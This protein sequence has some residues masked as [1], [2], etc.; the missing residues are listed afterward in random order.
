M[1]LDASAPGEKIEDEDNDC[2]NQKK[3][4]P[5]AKRIAAYQ[6]DNPKNDK[7]DGDR[8]KHK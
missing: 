4:N 7:N 1:L 2:E 5:A 8:P 3:M 6:A